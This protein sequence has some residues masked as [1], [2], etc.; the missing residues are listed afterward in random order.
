MSHQGYGPQYQYGPPP[1]PAA[2]GGA[3]VAVIVGVILFVILGGGLLVC[4]GF[5]YFFMRMRNDAEMQAQAAVQAEY[6]ATPPMAQAAPQTMPEM[7]IPGIPSLESPPVTELAPLPGGVGGGLPPAAGSPG[8][9]VTEQT[10]LQV[11]DKLLAHWAGQWHSVRVL[12]LRS[13]G[14]VKIHWDGWADS[15]DDYVSRSQLRK[16]PAE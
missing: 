15:W 12:E 6:A 10:P 13:D 16:P 5:G 14:K 8:E 11:G 3:T 9:Q 1:K 7:S 4:G 2:G